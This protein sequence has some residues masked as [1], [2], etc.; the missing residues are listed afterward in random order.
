MLR[1]LSAAAVK[2]SVQSNSAF[3][4][5]SSFPANARRLRGHSKGNNQPVSVQ[6]C[7]TAWRITSRP[8]AVSSPHYRQACC[9][10]QPEP[11]VSGRIKKMCW[12]RA[13]YSPRGKHNTILYFPFNLLHQIVAA[14]TV[15][16][17]RGNCYVISN[18]RWIYDFI[19]PTKGLFFN[20]W[21][22]QY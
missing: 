16:L 11:P 6:L 9:H 19:S 14:P 1:L 17:K 8:V 18:G 10:G 12:V 13:R 4:I 3:L 2:R 5:T 21:K 20:F 22:S 7:P 15:E